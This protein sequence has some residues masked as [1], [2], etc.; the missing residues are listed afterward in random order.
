MGA[1]YITPNYRGSR[2]YGTE[3]TMALPGH[4]GTVDVED[5]MKALSIAIDKGMATC[6]MLLCSPTRRLLQDTSI[7]IG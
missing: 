3:F 2:G 1:A 6:L 4:I 5:C 7:P